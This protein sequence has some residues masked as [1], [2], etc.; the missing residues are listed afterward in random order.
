M[1]IYIL[2]NGE[3]I[4]PF[5]KDAAQILI[6]QGTVSSTDL[7]WQP[8]AF[9]WRPLSDLLGTAPV[10]APQAAEPSSQPPAVA[11]AEPATAAQIAFLSYFGSTIS[12]GLTK[13][14]A[15]ALVTTAREDPANAKRL[16]S[17]ETDRMR[18]HPDLF[19]PEPQPRQ[20]D[21]VELFLKLCQTEGADR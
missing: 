15:E 20:E 12:Q 21:R 10:E 14:A 1:E 6:E 13:D 19:N 16:A 2:R 17:W 9:D 3:R 8:G 4:G 18:L 7:G 11:D 5:S